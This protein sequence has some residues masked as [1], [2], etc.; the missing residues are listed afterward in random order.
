MQQLLTGKKCLPGFVKE[1]EKQVAMLSSEFDNTSEIEQA[2]QTKQMATLNSDLYK[3]PGE[4]LYSNSNQHSNVFNGSNKQSAPRP[5][6]KHSELGEIP[7]DWE[8]VGLGDLF[9]NKVIR[10]RI[11]D[12]DN[13]TFIGMQ[14]VS[15]SAKIRSLH[16][17]KY[18]EV[19]S[20]FTYFERNDVLVA[21]ITPCFENGKGAFTD[22]LETDVGFGS[23]EFHVL[24]ATSNTDS[25]YLYYFTNTEKFRKELEG[26]MVGSAGHR[27]VPLSS[28]QSY[29]VAISK[30]KEEQTSIASVLSD[31]D[32][33]LDAL[34]QRLNKTQ[35]IKQGM[36]QELLTGKTRLV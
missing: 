23:T 1:S 24:R 29:Q 31:M 10:K 12:R 18:S 30:N 20:G 15:E 14:D 27:R 9:E 3:E 5:G 36:M 35:K 22:V 34:K 33:E 25:K 2:A 13:V 17:V 11:S 32:T 8:V 6:Y 19:K 28:I 4:G 7:E 16:K 21:K 26:E